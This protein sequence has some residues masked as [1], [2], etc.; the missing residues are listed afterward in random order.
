M[1]QYAVSNISSD[2]NKGIKLLELFKTS[3]E[4]ELFFWNDSYII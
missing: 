1:S 2:S 4:L 3:T